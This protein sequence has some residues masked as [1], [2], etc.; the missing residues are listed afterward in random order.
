MTYTLG[1]VTTSAISF[2][3]T[4]ATQQTIDLAG[5]SAGN[6]TFNSASNGNFAFTSAINMDPSATITHT[7]GALHFDGPSDNSGLTHSIGKFAGTGSTVRTLNLGSATFNV[8]GT[9]IAWNMSNS[10]NIT[11]SGANAT[12]ISPTT[13]G[14]SGATI[15]F[16][17]G[18]S[19][20]PK[21]I[22]TVRLLGTAEKAL[23][24]SSGTTLQIGTFER[25]GPATAAPTGT[26][27]VSSGI[28][29]GGTLK[30]TG[31]YKVHGDSAINRAMVWP[32]SNGIPTIL[33]VS[34]ATLDLAY[35]NF[36]DITFKNGGSNID[37]SAITGGSGDAGGNTISG[38]GT[39]SF[40]APTTQTWQTT[41]AGSFS[42]VTKWTSRIPLPQDSIVLNNAFSG[43][44]TITA[45][46]AWTGNI[47]FA[48][49]SGN[50]TIS[51]TPLGGVNVLGNFTGRSGVTLTSSGS[52]FFWNAR[53]SGVT[54]TFNG[55]TNSAINNVSSSNGGDLTFADNFSMIAGLSVRS[56]VVIIPTGVTVT[57][58]T[59]TSNA[60]N[61]AA[62]TDLR[63][64]GTLALNNSSGTLFSIA[65]A[66]AG[67]N[68]FGEYGGKISIVNTGA[69]AKT[70][71]GNGNTFTT[72]QIPSGTGGVTITGANTFT[73][74]GIQAPS[75][76]KVTLPGSTTT[77]LNAAASGLV[78]GNG[79]NLLTLAPS[80]GSA[81]LSFGAAATP[82]FLDLT[83]IAAAGT[84]PVHAGANS[85]DHGG[86]TN[87]IFP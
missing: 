27:F 16:T 39:L 15:S 59:F 77:T 51:A 46:M 69:S 33:D 61:S 60:T 55:A 76:G 24:I 83:N 44:P 36:Q 81:T 21:V 28:G 10:A 30:I 56:G 42:D 82:N 70:F 40:T 23:T 68:V 74:S 67:I 45:D 38:G 5:K 73:G 25:S 26:G 72:L 13:A 43:T 6:I 35:V 48:G 87:W 58:P 79:S 20:T 57:A 19:A 86:N 75:G 29:T 2:V 8:L 3:S 54:L 41:G 14:A 17:F 9:S 49:G 64:T 1:N 7:A 53:T 85:V 63:I 18:A 31:T 37:L 4:S 71:A 66:G 52:S 84:T 34:G 11:F 32:G 80:A 12:I 78:F 50:V 62:P 65:T 22:G 47:S